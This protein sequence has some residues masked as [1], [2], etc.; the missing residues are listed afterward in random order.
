MR[1][2]TAKVV[3]TIFKRVEDDNWI[4]ARELRAMTEGRGL[5]D[6]ELAWCNKVIDEYMKL[7]KRLKRDLTMKGEA[8]ILRLLTRK[9]QRISRRRGCE[10]G[11]WSV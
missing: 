3:R 4:S 1:L 8:G 9:P 6:T 10:V 7:R 5:S 11:N 2:A